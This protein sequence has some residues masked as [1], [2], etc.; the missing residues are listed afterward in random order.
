MAQASYSQLQR[1]RPSK[2]A[3]ML[4]GRSKKHCSIYKKPSSSGTWKT[5]MLD[6]AVGQQNIVFAEVTPRTSP[7]CVTSTNSMLGRSFHPM[8]STEDA[9]APSTRNAQQKCRCGMVLQRFRINA[10][11]FVVMCPDVQCTLDFGDGTAEIHQADKDAI[12]DGKEEKKK[13]GRIVNQR[14]W[15]QELPVAVPV[16]GEDPNVVGGSTTTADAEIYRDPAGS[17]H[18]PTSITIDDDLNLD[19]LPI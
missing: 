19:D 18:S 17:K 5:A 4:D 2:R 6:S 11:D 7:E 8:K 9:V 15:Q 16:S 10:K 1:K 14:F 12:V 3:L 13:T